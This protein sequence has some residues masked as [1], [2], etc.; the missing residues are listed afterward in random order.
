MRPIHLLA[1]AAVPALMAQAPAKSLTDIYAAETTA[2]EQ[3]LKEFKGEEAVARL[4]GVIPATLP[5][6]AKPTKEEILKDYPGSLGKITASQGAYQG[7]AGLNMLLAKAHIAAGQFE[8]AKET[9]VKALAIA[10]QNQDEFRVAVEPVRALWA[11]LA[12][13][14]EKFKSE[15]EPRAKEFEAKAK[16]SDEENGFLTWYKQNLPVHEQ[17][18]KNAKQINVALDNQIAD[19]GK[20]IDIVKAPMAGLEK[21]IQDQAEEIKT[22]NDDQAKKKKK[23]EGNKTWVNAVLNKQ[24]N[25]T[26]LNGTKAQVEFLNRLLVLDPGNE[27]ATKARTNLLA[28]REPFFKEAAAKPAKGAKKS[29]KG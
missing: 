29:K 21:N 14:A 11:D 22:F 15:N 6:Y 12:G 26:K 4:K 23:V 18:I 16:K 5:T 1:L 24:E 10:K 25:V 17:N 20:A 27:A 2:V 8:V 13:N 28:G 7:L 19:L 9:L 3:L